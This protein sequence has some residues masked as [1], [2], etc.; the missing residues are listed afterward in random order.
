MNTI[1][2]TTEVPDGFQCEY[3]QVGVYERSH[4]KDVE[5]LGKPRYEYVENPY[6]PKTKTVTL[7]SQQLETID[8]AEI[9]LAVNQPHI[10]ARAQTKAQA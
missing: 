4:T 1:T 5:Q 7:F 2:I 6:R 10:I 8:M 3:K 9:I